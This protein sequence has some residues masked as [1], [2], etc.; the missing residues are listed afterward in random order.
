MGWNSIEV[1]IRNE[2]AKRALA[3]INDRYT[4]MYLLR[5]LPRNL[6]QYLPHVN[7][8]PKSNAIFYLVE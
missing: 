4:H 5:H 3:K 8:Y 1:L 6:P 2:H 7:Y